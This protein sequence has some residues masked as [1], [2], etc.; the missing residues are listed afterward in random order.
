MSFARRELSPARLG[1]NVRLVLAR[2]PWI[3]WLAVGLVAAVDRCLGPRSTA[4]AS[5]RRG[6]SGPISGACPSRT[7][8]A[9]PG[10]VLTW[11][12]QDHPR[13]RR[14]RR[15]RVGD[16]RRDDRPTTCRD[17]RD[18]RRRR[19]RRRRGPGGGSGRGPRRRPDQRP[20]GDRSVG[21][22]STWRST[23]TGWCSPPTSRI[24]HVD[25]DRGLRGD[26]R[27]RC[28]DGR[29]SGPDPTGIDR[30][31]RTALTSPSPTPPIGAG[32]LRCDSNRDRVAKMAGTT[33][34]GRRAMSDDE[35][36][37][38]EDLTDMRLD[39]DALADLLDAG[40]ECVFNWTTKD[41]HPVGVVVA[42]VYHDGKFFTTCA[43]R[44]KRVPALRARPQSGIVIN[45][46]RQ[47]CDVQGRV[48]RPRAR[49]SGLRRTQAVV[50][51]EVVTRRRATRRRVPAEL[52]QV[53]RLAAPRDHRN[54]RP[55]R[56]GVRHRQVPCVHAAG[57]GGRSRRRLNL[58][59]KRCA[60]RWRSARG[61]RC[62]GRRGR[63]RTA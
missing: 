61:R 57:D 7:A 31:R 50:L 28:A 60:R 29:C 52:Q 24:V 5:M 13:H 15:C 56:R 45:N 23:A 14:P 9:S 51:R 40:G 58:S 1:R 8:D 22:A 54:R 63:S 33:P 53:P 6:H 35:Q 47:D 41:G 20:A 12:W 18:R 4:V 32:P 2:R 10:D 17:G 19:P 39:D 30:V 46:A 49:R 11:E 34:D 36:I 25:G 44:R 26:G 38:Y 43:E 27:R 3:R 16:L 62:R 21:R 55:P 42:F 59:P 48:G 37:D